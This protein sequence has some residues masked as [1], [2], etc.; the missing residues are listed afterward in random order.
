MDVGLYWASLG[1]NMV[2]EIREWIMLVAE[3]YICWILTMEYFYDA[4]KDAKKQ[5]RTKTTKKTT[6]KAGESVVEETSEVS[7]PIQEIKHE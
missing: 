6:S 4:A 2:T 3:L 7:E 1:L 5:R